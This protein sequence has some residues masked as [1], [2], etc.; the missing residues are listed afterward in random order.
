MKE[1]IG[2]D[3]S[4]KYLNSLNTNCSII[5]F[6]FSLFEGG[7]VEEGYCALFAWRC[8]NMFELPNPYFLLLNALLPWSK[9]IGWIEEYCFTGSS[10]G[11]VI[12]DGDT[13][14]N[15]FS[16]VENFF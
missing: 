14:T 5:M 15:F 13:D 6:D 4:F 11:L 7:I 10:Y 8:W 9:L 3:T 1:N 2:K 12:L 16:S